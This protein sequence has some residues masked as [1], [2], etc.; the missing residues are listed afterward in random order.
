MT[1]STVSEVALHEAAHCVAAFKHGIAVR[2]VCVARREVAL[3]SPGDYLE[4]GH[5]H[6]AVAMAYAITALAGQAAA[7][8]TGLSKFDQQLLEHSVFLGSWA[9][10][11]DDMRRAL[12]ALATH[13]VSAHREAIEKLAL[14]LDQRSGTMSGVEVEVFLGSAVR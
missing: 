8:A 12:S 4:R 14:V 13:F 3:E 6:G 1:V 10:D 7:P 9:D 11:P 5:H 2:H